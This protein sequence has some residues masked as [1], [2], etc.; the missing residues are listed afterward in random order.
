VRG[1]SAALLALAALATW[2]APAA[3]RAASGAALYQQHC[4]ACHQAAGTGLPGAFPPLAGNP[5]LEDAAHVR[6]VI[7]NGL[8]GPLHVGGEQYDGTMPAFKG[9][10]TNAEIQALTDHVRSAWGNAFGAS[11]AT[12]AGETTATDAAAATPAPA[13][14]APS[15]GPAPRSAAPASPTAAGDAALG[16]ALFSGQRRFQNGAPPCSACHTVQGENPLGGGT[17]GRDLTTAYDR[18]GQSA[19]LTGVLTNIAFP[20]MRQAFSTRPLTQPEIADLVAYLRQSATTAQQ[21]GTANRDPGRFGF[22]WLWLLGLVGA[23]LLFALL[24]FGWPRQRESLAQRLRRTG[25]L[26][27]PRP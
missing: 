9:Q 11:G 18:L 5:A 4:A 3:A 26:G 17:M 2:T 10:L 13:G 7:E 25:H 21:R 22:N 24:L 12:A 23:A 27:R 1:A 15:S 19:G 8:S 6:S 20:V 16:R 14:G